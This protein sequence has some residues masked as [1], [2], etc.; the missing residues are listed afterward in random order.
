MAPSKRSRTLLAAATAALVAIPTA[1]SAQSF[2]PADDPCL[3]DPPPAEYEDRDQ[4]IEIHLP[5]VDC[6]TDNGIF[7][8]NISLEGRR[9]NPAASLTRAQMASIIARA[10]DHAGYELPAVPPDAFEDDTTSVHQLNIN[11]LAAVGIVK[12]RTDTE[13]D[14]ESPVRRDQMASFLVRAA[15]KAYGTE[16]EPTSSGGFSDVLEGNVHRENVI[17]AS[18]ILGLAIG[19]PNGTFSPAS[20]TRRDHAAT[21]ISRLVDMILIDA[22]EPAS[23]PASGPTTNISDEARDLED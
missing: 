17:V 6:T 23:D 21:F 1:A 8:G 15:E 7:Q 19:H 10:L 4:I 11:R 5:A 9:F 16:F 20:M 3:G 18:E 22:E 2:T 14:P 12:G 13:F